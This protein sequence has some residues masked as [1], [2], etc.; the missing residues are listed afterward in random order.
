[1]GAIRLKAFVDKDRHLIIDLPP[2]VPNGVVN[3]MIEAA[4]M[5]T[6]NDLLAMPLEER[7]KY[8]AI[9]A[10]LA[11]EFY[12]NDPELTATSETIDLYDYPDE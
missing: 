7:D 8:L 3:V 1:M 5:P 12:E 11:A 2:E 10:E 9:Q 6:L 4:T